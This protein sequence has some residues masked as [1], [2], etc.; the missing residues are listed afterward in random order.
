LKRRLNEQLLGLPNRHPNHDGH[1]LAER[2][3]KQW[4]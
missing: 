1:G 4:I 3:L 2:A